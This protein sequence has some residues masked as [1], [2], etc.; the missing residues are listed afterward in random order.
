[1]STASPSPRTTAPASRATAGTG[2]PGNQDTGASPTVVGDGCRRSH[3]HGRRLQPV[4]DPLCRNRTCAYG[5]ATDETNV[6]Y[7]NA[8]T[9]QGHW[10]YVMNYE[11]QIKVDG[12]G[13]IRVRNYDHNCRDDQEL[14]PERHRGEQLRRRRERRARSPSPPRTVMPLPSATAPP[15]NGGLLAASL[16]SDARRRLRG[17]VV[18]HRRRQSRF[19]PV[20][21]LYLIASASPFSRQRR[22][23]DV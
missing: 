1:M 9:S 14:R 6:Y 21:A 15:P 17:A 4:R 13:S 20:A 5:S 22:R 11:K 16:I 2:R 7:L 10:T 19:G 8:D 23:A 3:V 18:A 12:G